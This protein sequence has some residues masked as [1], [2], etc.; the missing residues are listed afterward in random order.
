[1]RKIYAA[2]ARK[3]AA[4][5]WATFPLAVGKKV[6]TAGSHGFK[7]ASADP[8]VVAARAAEYPDANIGIATGKVSG[9]I[10]IDIDP[11]NGGDL[12]LKRLAAAGKRFPKTVEA[13]SCQNGRHLYYAYDRRAKSCR[14]SKLGM[15]IDVKMDGGYVVAPPSV[16]SRNGQAYRWLRSPQRSAVRPLPRWIVDALQS[17]PKPKLHRARLPPP[18]EFEGYRRQALA[19]LQRLAARM[20]ALGDGR[21]QA[22]F[23]MACRIGKY[24]RHGL[25]SDAE[26][27]EAFLAACASN[28]AL[29]KYT[30]EDLRAQ[31]KNGLR[32]A[33]NDEL[34]PLRRHRQQAP[35]VMNG[36]RRCGR[37]TR[38]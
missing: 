33:A 20:A 12:T 26:I 15:G 23:I 17:P 27:E 22:P 29:A 14:K 16:W 13:I 9:L 36:P 18:H 24:Q 32:R 11:R 31:I 1:M 34:P 6:P 25:L 37:R 30:S 4:L 19:Q 28:G 3:Y 2:H 21:H 35:D 5:R 38:L 10:V 7:S 8:R